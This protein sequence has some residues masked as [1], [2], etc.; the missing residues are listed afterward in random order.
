MMRSLLLAGGVSLAAMLAP[1]LRADDDELRLRVPG[2]AAPAGKPADTR[3]LAMNSQDDEAETLEM[4]WRGGFVGY[5]GGFVGYRGFGFG[6]FHR[7]VFVGGGFYRG[8]G[9]GGFHRPVFVG[10]GFYRGFGGFHPGFVGGGF[11]GGGFF[12]PPIYTAPFVNYGY[13][14]CAVTEAT[15]VTTLAF[16][17]E[18]AVPAPVD[19][20]LPTRPVLPRPSEGAAPRMPNADGTFDYNGGPTNPVPALPMPPA[21][22]RDVMNLPRVPTPITERYVSDRPEPTTGKYVYPAYGETPRRSGK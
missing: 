12:P 18:P 9:F 20:S 14:P 6:G 19:S 13:F 21:S 15:P 8:F 2:Q 17:I 1:A 7:P 4:R 10:G 16:R 11:V 22:E 3:T 5:R